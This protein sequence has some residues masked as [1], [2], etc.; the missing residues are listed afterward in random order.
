M[1]GRNVFITKTKTWLAAN[2][3]ARKK[4]GFHKICQAKVEWQHYKNLEARS[5]GA[6]ESVYNRETTQLFLWTEL[7]VK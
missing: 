2:R 6:K 5:L 3:A 4:Q 1:P 7:F